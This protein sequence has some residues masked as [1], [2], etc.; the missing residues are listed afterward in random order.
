MTTIPTDGPA[1]AD[2]GAASYLDVAE[3]LVARAIDAE[4]APVDPLDWRKASLIGAGLCLVV[5]ALETVNAYVLRQIEGTPRSWGYTIQE[6]L[7]W[8]VLWMVFVPLVLWLAQHFR[9]DG[10]TWRRSAFVH[11]CTGILIAMAHAATFAVGL[12]YWNPTGAAQGTVGMDV[13]SFL[14]RYLF[15]DI[16]TYCAAVGVYYAF[17]YFSG[18]RRS[19]LAAA[20]SE[21]RAARLKLN[22]AEARMHALRM[23]L[24]P[25]FLF[26]A[27]NAVAGLV[28]RREHDGAIAM[29]SRLGELLRTT[30]NRDLPTEVPLSQELELLRHFLEIEVVRFGDR[31]RV[32][33]EVEPEAQVALVPPL[34]LQPLVENAL[35]HGISRRQGAALLRIS[36]RRSGLHLELA[37]RDTGEGLAAHGSRAPREGIGLSNTRA[38]LEQLYGRDAILLELTDVPGGGART[39]ILLPYHLDAGRGHVA[40]GA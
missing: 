26:N 21:A 37:V 12:H 16:M 5:G 33:W 24:N 27:L 38:R 34:I 6:Q 28:R 29:L 23:E 1:G 15:M 17:E 19:A 18:F 35:R 13:R 32:A 31:L 22:L 36:A 40:L 8:W 9:F 2:D 20:T 11:G 3:P 25:H 30:L 39:R 4:P 10:P 14:L 7:P